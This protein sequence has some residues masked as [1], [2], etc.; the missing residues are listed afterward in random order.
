MRRNRP[1]RFSP[2]TRRASSRVMQMNRSAHTPFVPVIAEGIGGEAAGVGR[3][4][5]I[6]RR[7]QTRQK[8]ERLDDEA[9]D[10]QKFFLRSSAEYMLAT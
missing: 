9:G 1:T 7:R 8:Y 10:L 6:D 3:P 5:E 2:V 4:G